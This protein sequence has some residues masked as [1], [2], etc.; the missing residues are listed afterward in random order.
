MIVQTFE[1]MLK[2]ALDTFFG[3]NEKINQYGVRLNVLDL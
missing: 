2:G 1:K 3:T